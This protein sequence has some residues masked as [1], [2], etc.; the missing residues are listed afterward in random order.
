MKIIY[1]SNSQTR[2][3]E[4]SKSIFRKILAKLLRNHLVDRDLAVKAFRAAFMDDY[5][6]EGNA[7]LVSRQ[8]LSHRYALMVSR[9]FSFDDQGFADSEMFNVCSSIVIVFFFIVN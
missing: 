8:L 3:Y 6:H 4:S 2:F 9:I 7:R 5:N 1:F